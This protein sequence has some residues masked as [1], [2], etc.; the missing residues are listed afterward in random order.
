M[1]SDPPLEGELVEV[2]LQPDVVVGRDDGLGQAL[3]LL[4]A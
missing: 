1:G 2:R 4:S 3:E